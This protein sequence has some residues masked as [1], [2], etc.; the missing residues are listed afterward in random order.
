MIV[1]KFGGTSVGTPERIRALADLVAARIDQAPVVVVSAFSGITDALVHG[2]QLAL[3][4]D[5][6]C[7]RVLS[8]TLERHRDAVHALVPPGAE[9]RTTKLAS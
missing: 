2:A 5:A 6:A 4:R 9:C 8:S 3:A 7:A 1:M